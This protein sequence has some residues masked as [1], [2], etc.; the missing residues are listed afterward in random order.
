M[1]GLPWTLR[2]LAVADLVATWSKDPS[3]KVGAVIVDAHR[4][5][6]STGY[7]GLPQRV[8]DLPIRYEDK[9][10]KYPII[11]HAEVNAIVC[12]GRGVSNCLLVATTA[13][14]SRC[15]AMI[16]QSGIRWVAFPDPALDERMQREPWATD[17]ALAMLMLN[18]AEVRV[19]T[20]NREVPDEIPAK[21]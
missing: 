4:R 5:I 2:M 1:I 18:E 7:N 10:L 6:V 11:V 13:P 15:A 21:K 16:I 17:G 14:C 3:T 20:L 19:T 12:S 8:L 9:N